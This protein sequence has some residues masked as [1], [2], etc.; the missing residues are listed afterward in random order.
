MFG[1]FLKVAGI[2]FVIDSI[3]LLLGW[4]FYKDA[5]DAKSEKGMAIIRIFVISL[6]AIV[7]LIGL[8][9]VFGGYQGFF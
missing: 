1:M 5:K 9:W 7:T 3:L 8:C 2:V 4:T 6:V